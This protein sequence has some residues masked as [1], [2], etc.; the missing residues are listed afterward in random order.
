MARDSA[1]H[2][3]KQV[4]KITSMQKCNTFVVIMIV[5]HHFDIQAEI[6]WKKMHEMQFRPR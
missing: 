4:F 5:D 1:E 3:K 2:C 6:N